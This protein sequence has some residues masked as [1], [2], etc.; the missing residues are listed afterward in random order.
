MSER[1]SPF[2]LLRL[3]ADGTFRSGEVLRRELGCSRAELGEL[4]Q[5]MDLLGLR[6]IAVRGRGFGLSAPVDLIRLED[7]SGSP[8][9]VEILDECE[10]TN[11]MLVARAR[12]AAN[13]GSL[14]ASAIVCERQ[15]AGRGRRGAQ[16][17]APRFQRRV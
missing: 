13:V 17:L 16:W 2:F 5:A 4:V 9:R 8:F 3:L 1:Q 6:V 15:N 14:H 11:T 10:S 12:S 7:L